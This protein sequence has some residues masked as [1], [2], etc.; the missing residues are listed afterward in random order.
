VLLGV[1]H[2]ARLEPAGGKV[3]LRMHRLICV[4]VKDG[5]NTLEGTLALLGG[6]GD[7][8][9]AIGEKKNFFFQ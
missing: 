6:D 2:A 7:V 9:N 4:P 1:R 5:R 8:V 3:S